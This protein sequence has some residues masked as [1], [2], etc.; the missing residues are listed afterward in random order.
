MAKADLTATYAAP[1]GQSSMKI[2]VASNGN[3]RSQRIPGTRTVI[4]RDG[5]SYLID[6]SHGRPTVARTDDLA[7]VTAEIMAKAQPAVWEQ[8]THAPHRI[9][10]M[11]GSMTINGRT[12]DA[13][14]AQAPDGTL[15]GTPFVVISH[16]PALAPL[17]Q[18][19]AVQF[20]L[21]EK[22]SP[23][24]RNKSVLAALQQGTALIL[25]GLEL[26]SVSDAP[27]DPSAFEL[28]A[29]AQTPDELRKRM[30]ELPN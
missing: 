26:Q 24:G 18:A 28:P 6:V 7:A 19:M 14:Y 21:G 4:L 10:V 12:G 20:E 25:N 11:K 27:V 30:M 17:G 22:M 8:M 29:A 23:S 15:S 13:Y 1:N 2:E 16:D 5:Q 3:L 9:L